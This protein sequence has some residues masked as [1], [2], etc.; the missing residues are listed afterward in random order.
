[1]GLERRGTTIAYY[2]KRRVGKRVVSK[3]ISSGRLAELAH[4]YDLAERLKRKLDKSTTESDDLADLTAYCDQV[5]RA[6][7]G[8]IAE[9]GYH[10]QNRGPWRK[11]R[12]LE[13]GRGEA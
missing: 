2:Q 13:V 10:R 4:E 9:S 1:M 12:T 7:V 8:A 11:Q 5:E 6:I 3:Y